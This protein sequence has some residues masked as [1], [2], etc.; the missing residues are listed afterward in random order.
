[1]INMF[2]LLSYDSIF[3]TQNC[4]VSLINIGQLFPGHKMLTD[5]WLSGLAL[6]VCFD[7]AHT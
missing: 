6:S 7:I 1:M 4:E 5:K 2:N 3:F